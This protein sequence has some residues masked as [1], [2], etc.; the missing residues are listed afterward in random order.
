LQALEQE[1][2]FSVETV[3]FWRAFP[4][5]V[6]SGARQISARQIECLPRRRLL[7]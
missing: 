4:R 5:W 3:R 6:M 7:A 2:R 1:I